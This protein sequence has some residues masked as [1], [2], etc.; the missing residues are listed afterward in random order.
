MATLVCD[1]CGGKLVMS[2]G[3]IAVCDT[4]GLE[5]SIERMREKVQNIKGT[6][7]IAN[8]NMVDTWMKL[9]Q[10]ASEAG[11]QKEAYEYYAKVVEVEPTNWKAIFGK[12][13]A[14]AW[15]STL[16]NSRTSELYYAVKMA[17]EIIEN[18]NMPAEDIVNA[19]NEFAVAIY[20]VNN[21]FLELRK[22]NFDKHTDKYY[23][24]HWNEWWETHFTQATTNINQTE[25][26]I[27]L[28]DGLDDDLSRMTVLEMKKH[29]C[30]TLRFICDSS[31]TCWDSYSKNYLKCMGLSA[32]VKTPFVEKYMKLVIEI[33]EKEPD[34]ATDK[35]SQINPFNTPAIWSYEWASSLHDELLKHCQKQERKIKAIR[36][37]ELAQQR[38]E[39]YWQIHA[40]EKKQHMARINE[41]DAEIERINGIYNGY[42]AKIYEIEKDLRKNVPAEAQLTAIKKQQIE[43][44]EEKSKLGIFAGKHKKQLQDQIDSLQSQM[45]NIKENIKHQKRLIHDDVYARV[46]II[47]DERKPLKDQIC[48]LEEEKNRINLELKKAR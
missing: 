25:D 6:V 41:I 9:A 24:V 19:K 2:S 1:I 10:S 27:T 15:Q 22:N 16:A 11:N 34:Y 42:E 13:K 38:R 30:E 14:A 36:D 35:Y 4:C 29:I 21:A 45:A 8:S 7:Q 33:R 32:D 3:G 18:S 20:S 40:E 17:I 48:M 44:N 47:E 5:Y 39:E 28:L 26:V 43:L 23:N 46:N 37:K 12:G 31:D